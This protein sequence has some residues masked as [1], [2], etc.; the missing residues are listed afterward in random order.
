MWE[1]VVMSTQNMNMFFF[2]NDT[3]TTEIYT[4]SLHDALPVA[5]SRSV[6]CPTEIPRTAVRLAGAEDAMGA[7]SIARL[8]RG[9]E[10]T[11][12]CAM[13]HPHPQRPPATRLLGDDQEGIRQAPHP[14][15][16]PR[17]HP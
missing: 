3:A 2:F 1:L 5:R 7:R 9:V 14:V 6:Q 8:A 16:H 11:Y 17:R 12:G 10:G 15:L 4:L 13:P